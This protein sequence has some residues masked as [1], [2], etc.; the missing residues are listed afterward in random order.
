MKF[1]RCSPSN[2][3]PGA[4]PVYSIYT[5]YFISCHLCPPQF[6][7]VADLM[8]YFEDIMVKFTSIFL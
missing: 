1:F 7:F 6:L 2:Q 5:V 8:I 3:N 4:A